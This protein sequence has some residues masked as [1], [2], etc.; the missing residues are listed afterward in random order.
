MCVTGQIINYWLHVLAIFVR[1]RDEA[2]LCQI[3]AGHEKSELCGGAESLGYGSGV[4]QLLDVGAEF[5]ASPNV[6]DTWNSRIETIL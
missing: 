2:T 1:W 4:H 6:D 5:S 3:M